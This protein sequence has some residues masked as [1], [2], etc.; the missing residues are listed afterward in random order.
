MSFRQNYTW[1]PSI[2]HFQL[3]RFDNQFKLNVNFGMFILRILLSLG[4]H[5]WEPDVLDTLLY[6]KVRLFLKF[7]IMRTN[8]DSISQLLLGPEIATHLHARRIW[9]TCANY[10]GYDTVY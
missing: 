6:I 8:Y 1:I 9:R 10:S 2:M 5:L 4:T 7:I 3:I